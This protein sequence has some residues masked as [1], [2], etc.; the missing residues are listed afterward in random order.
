MIIEI[1]KILSNVEGMKGNY[2]NI[3]LQF[4]TVN[5]ALIYFYYF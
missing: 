2:G 4:L 1:L 5:D 3:S